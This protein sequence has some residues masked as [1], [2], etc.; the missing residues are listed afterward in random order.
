M[1]AK[2]GAEMEA[3]RRDA[4]AAWRLAKEL[5][6]RVTQQAKMF[7]ANNKK[8][9]KALEIGRRLTGEEPKPPSTPVDLT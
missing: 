8:F 9:S 5:E 6:A 1:R 4:A 3:A 7:T 2:H